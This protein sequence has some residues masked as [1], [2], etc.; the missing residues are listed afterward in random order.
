MDARYLFI[1]AV[2]FFGLC[3]LFMRH[4]HPYS[5]SRSEPFER[6]QLRRRIGIFCLILSFAFVTIAILAISLISKG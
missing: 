3:V 2:V 4:T 5:G 1:P 6:K